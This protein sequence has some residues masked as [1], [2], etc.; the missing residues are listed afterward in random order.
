MLSYRPSLLYYSHYGIA[1]G[2]VDKL[3]RLLK[4]LETW[5]SAARDLGSEDEY[6]DYI[7]SG[8]E[9]FRRIYARLEEIPLSK[10]LVDLAIKGVYEWVRERG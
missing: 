2:G 6:R 1:E 10:T 7:T 8:D 5:I 4:T 3:S 9:E